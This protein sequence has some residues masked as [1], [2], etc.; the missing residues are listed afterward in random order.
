MDGIINVY[1]E[2]GFT[3]HDV[4]AK[5]RG[6]LHIKKIKDI[7]L[8]FKPTREITQPILDKATFKNEETLS[9][10]V[11]KLGK[12][13]AIKLSIGVKITDTKPIIK[14]IIPLS[15]ALIINQ[16]PQFRHVQDS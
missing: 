14:D 4:V 16:P 10:A 7:T 12:A 5:L 6:I 9:K 3:S 2:K 1:K 15:K 8:L 13:L 11:D